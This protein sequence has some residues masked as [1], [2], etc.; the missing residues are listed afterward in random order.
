MINVF[1][2]HAPAYKRIVR[3]YAL[4]VWRNRGNRKVFLEKAE[5]YKRKY[6]RDL[7]EYYHKQEIKIHP[8][9]I[10][11]KAHQWLVDQRSLTESVEVVAQ[12]K[13]DNL[14]AELFDKLRKQKSSDVQKMLDKIYLKQ[15]DVGRGAEVYKVFSFS[16]NLEARAE[17]IGEQA[18]FDLGADINHAVI[19]DIGDRYQWNTQ[20]DS[21][22]RKTHKMLNKKTFLYSDPPTTVDK[23]GNTHTGHPGTDYGCRCFEEPST[24]KPRLSYT[25]KE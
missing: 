16:E 10:K 1:K 17:Q 6:E 21:R 15:K 14:T 25:A 2:K 13:K 7:V 8:E 18:A 9:T 3:K 4:D 24:S 19:E 11:A 12:A 22:V 23:Y 20:E 5:R